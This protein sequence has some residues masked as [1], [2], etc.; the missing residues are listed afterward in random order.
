MSLWQLWQSFA[1][2]PPHLSV[3]EPWQETLVQ[4]LVSVLYEPPMPVLK[5][6][7]LDPFMCS[8]PIMAWPLASTVALWQVWQ[9]AAD[10]TC[11]AWPLYQT[12][13]MVPVVDLFV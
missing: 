10:F 8:V 3:T 9:S 12:P 1:N 2:L 4:R 13:R 7:S 11:L 6:T 5:L